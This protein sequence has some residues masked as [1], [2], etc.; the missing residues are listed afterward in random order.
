LTFYEPAHSLVNIFQYEVYIVCSK[1]RLPTETHEFRRLRKS[2]IALCVLLLCLQPATS[3]CYTYFTTCLTTL[4][5]NILSASY[6][7]LPLPLLYCGKQLCNYLWL[8]HA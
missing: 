5:A 3:Y 6:R 4:C 2:L 8:C 7:L 1:C